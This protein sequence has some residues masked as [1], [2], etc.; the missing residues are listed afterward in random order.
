[1]V[2]LA[3]VKFNFKYIY[4][5]GLFALLLFMH[6][7]HY[8]DS[9]E[10][11]I[12]EGAWNLINGKRLYFDFFEFIPPGGFYAIFWVWKIFGVNY[13][14][15]KLLG[16]V[17]IF[18]SSIGVYRIS[19]Q[20]V[21]N[22]FAGASSFVFI[23][24][25]AFWPIINHNTFN[26][27]FIVWAVYFF[28]KGLSG[29]EKKYFIFSGLLTGVS[30]L[31][32]QQRGVALL[33]AVSMFLIILFFKEKK[34]LILKLSFYYSLPA[35]AVLSLLAI[36]WPPQLLYQNLVLFPLSNYGKINNIPL[37]LFFL[38]AAAFLLI[39]LLLRR[40]R[41]KELWGLI[42]IQFF[43]LLSSLTRPDI[44]HIS[45]VI[46]PLYPLFFLAY[47]RSMHKFRASAYSLFAVIIMAPIIVSA[48]KYI[49]ASPPFYSIKNSA[50][51]S[52]IKK[53]CAESDYLYAGPFMPGMYFEARKLNA[54]PYHSI[55]M[56]G[57][58]AEE[59]I[60][61][62]KEILEKVQPACAV[63]NYGIVEK[64]NYNKNN[65]VDNYILDNYKLIFQQNNTLI[66]KITK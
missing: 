42:F 46:F 41:A 33:A 30:I 10:G 34:Y 25:S 48:F 50:A 37:Y 3:R 64:F 15:A 1:M 23:I 28:L 45:L 21:K 65:P 61:E 54:T 62:I 49:Y 32:L 27:L 6:A 9:D 53:N 16:V 52:Y 4:W 20:F 14:S 59:K 2:Q 13:L 18:L 58:R 66:Y 39:V 8:L 44:N 38:Y 12:L 7:S 11:V 56:F 63:L 36:K 40:Q 26:I 35:L 22:K 29:Y 19:G 31:F 43:L 24:S 51:L 55:L 5:A 17:I 47:G 57:G 60:K